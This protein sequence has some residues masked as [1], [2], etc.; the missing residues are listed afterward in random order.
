MPYRRLS[1][2][3]LIMIVED[4]ADLREAMT[5]T[6]ADDGY[7]IVAASDGRSALDCLRTGTL[8][9]LILLDLWMPEVDGWQLR[10]AVQRDSRLRA[11]PIVVVTGAHHQPVDAI[12]V[13]EV[14]YK[15]VDPA[16]LSGVIQRYC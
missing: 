15:P 5:A 9:H 8:P 14:L 3:R 1:R 13:A 6:L 4:D 12:Q 7:G 10:L 16:V 2:A 11:I